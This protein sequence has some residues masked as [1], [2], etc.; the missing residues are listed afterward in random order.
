MIQTGTEASV[1]EFL[2]LSLP[3]LAL[4]FAVIFGVLGW[5]LLKKVIIDY[6][7]SPLLANGI[8]MTIGGFFA[9]IHSY[10]C[11]ESWSPIPVTH[12]GPFMRNILSLGLISNL[13]CYNLYGYLLKRYSATFMSFAGLV[14]PLFASLFGWFF[15]KEQ[16]TWHYAASLAIFSVG[17]TLFYREELSQNRLQAVTNLA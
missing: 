1:G 9:L 10:A 8:S 17:L 14:T 7:Y 6:G 3:E 5:I 15:L 4:L 11:G 12:L 16:I 13:I 2:H